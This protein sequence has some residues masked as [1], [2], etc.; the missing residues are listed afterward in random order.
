MP[1]SS[2]SVSSKGRVIAS[3]AAKIDDNLLAGLQEQLPTDEHL[4]A[5]RELILAIKGVAGHVSQIPDDDGALSEEEAEAKAEGAEV[6][7]SFGKPLLNLENF[8]EKREANPNLASGEA[9]WNTILSK[10]PDSD[11]DAVRTTRDEL[12]DFLQAL[13]NL[14][15]YV[16]GPEDISNGN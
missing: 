13:K 4:Q 2:R 3:R 7:K 5:F 8:T 15:R 9:V 1:Q 10:W 6:F 16:M 12:Q 11:P 14:R